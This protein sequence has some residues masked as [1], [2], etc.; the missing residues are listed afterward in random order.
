MPVRL[1]A[2]VAR[3]IRFALV[4]GT[5]FVIDAGILAALHNGAGLDPFTARLISITASALTTWRLN[6][7]LTFGASPRSQAVEGVR[8]AT[9]AALTALLNYALYALALIVRPEV[10]PII[11]MIGATVAAMLFSYVGYSRFV[12]AGAA[13]VVGAPSSQSR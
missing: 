10:Q 3:F 4:G 9:V 8:Y 13:T 11:A 5:G 12:F 7:S 6:R 2:E 1:A